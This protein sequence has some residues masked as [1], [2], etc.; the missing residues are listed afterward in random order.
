VNHL[1]LTNRK[2]RVNTMKQ[3]K[4]YQEILDK[5]P[6][7]ISKEQLYKICHVSKRTASYLLESGLIPCQCSGKKSRKYKIDT[8]EVVKFMNKREECP[9]VFNAPPGWYKEIQDKESTDLPQKIKAKMQSHFKEAMSRY[10]DLL[11]VND[12][13]EMTG[14]SSAA[15]SRWCLSN[16]LRHFVIHKKYLIPKPYLL[17][18]VTGI[19]FY[20]MWYKSKKYLTQWG[21]VKI[22]K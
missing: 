6:S 9:D 7:E 8:N 20:T 16:T 2:G 13:G 5:Y 15:V 21:K 17:E 12:I 3:S 4:K 11:T 19:Q 22:Q 14:Y 10:P 1:P 18:Y